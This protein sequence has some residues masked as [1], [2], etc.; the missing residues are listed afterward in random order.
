MQFNVGYIP[1]KETDHL[2]THYFF[3][4]SIRNS[5]FIARGCN[6]YKGEIYQN[7]K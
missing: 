6:I 5:L 7:K 1:Y 3:S 2:E 4:L